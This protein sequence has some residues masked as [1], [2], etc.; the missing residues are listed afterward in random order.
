MVA[1]VVKGTPAEVIRQLNSIDPQAWED[2]KKRL[3]NTKGA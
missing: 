1:L 3:L 2:H